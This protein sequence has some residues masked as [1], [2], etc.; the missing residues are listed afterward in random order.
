MLLCI[1][2]ERLSVVDRV[3]NMGKLVVSTIIDLPTFG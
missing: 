2:V 3:F 1:G